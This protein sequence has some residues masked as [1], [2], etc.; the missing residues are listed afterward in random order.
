MPL[1]ILV[2]SLLLLGL[3]ILPSHGADKIKEPWFELEKGLKLCGVENI[4]YQ[5]YCFIGEDDRE[6][7]ISSFSSDPLHSGMAPP[8]CAWSMQPGY[9]NGEILLGICGTDLQGCADLWE[10]LEMTIGRCAAGSSRSWGVEGYLSGDPDLLDLGRGLIE[11]LGGR[12]QS[13]YVNGRMVQLAA[14]L[15]WAGEGLPLDGGQVNLLLEL[16][17][18]TAP[19][20]RVRARL[21]IPVLHSTAF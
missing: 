3:S 20:G 9:E 1:R 13:T 17:R 14:Y 19:A 16:Y 12:L 15:S 8:A 18:S 6:R 2:I 4:L 7:V 21:G 11:A 5:T 10:R